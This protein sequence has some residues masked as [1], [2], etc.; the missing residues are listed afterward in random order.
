MSEGNNMIF[1]AIKSLITEE[2]L[3]GAI[4]SVVAERMN[5]NVERAIRE[6]AER[7]A[8]EYCDEHIE[9]V[10]ADIYGRG[11]NLDDGF[12]GRRGYKTFEEYVRDYV[13]QECRKQWNMERNVKRMV[14]SRIEEVCKK[15][16]AE[17]EANLA[18]KAM[19]ILSGERK[20]E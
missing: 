4:R 1:E 13:G 19:R 17:N 9:D 16:V 12:G 8:R 18:D 11:V 15:V 6:E 14:E 10:L 2:Q 3:D 20:E 7:V 5:Y